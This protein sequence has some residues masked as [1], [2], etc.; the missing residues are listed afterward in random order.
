MINEWDEMCELFGILAY[1]V[2]NSNPDG[3]DMY[4]A[5]PAI[6]YHDRNTSKLVDIAKS[7]KSQ[8][9]S[10]SNI[11]RCLENIL[12]EYNRKLER[13]IDLRRVRLSDAPIEDLKPLS[14]YVFTNANWT[15]RSG[16][17]PAIT[18]IVDSLVAMNLPASQVGIQF[19]S[20]GSNEE[21]L[22]RLKEYDSIGLELYVTFAK[23]VEG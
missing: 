16:P 4:F 22:Q 6:R 1:L 13:Q 3:I 14:V 20:F 2:K 12:M 21:H 10:K 5:M 15:E 7:R 11:N 9:Q 17:E 23:S 8:L 18:R 19:I